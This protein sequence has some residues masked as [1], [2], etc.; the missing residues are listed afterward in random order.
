MALMMSKSEPAYFAVI[1]EV[2]KIWQAQSISFQ[3]FH[4]DYE[5]GHINALFAIF[6]PA[7]IF[8]CVF[9]YSNAIIR[10][11]RSEC[12]NINRSYHKEKNGPIYKWVSIFF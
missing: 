1:N 8:G 4:V 10:R 6:D 12:P 5:S 7:R 2:N 9:H 11:I 3:R